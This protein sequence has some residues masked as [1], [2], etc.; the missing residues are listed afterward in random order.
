MN[1]SAP[2]LDWSVA[3]RPLPGQL[4]SGDSHL[5]APF[6]GGALMAAIDGL[7]HG[8]D[9]ETASRVSV[10]VMREAPQ[11]PVEDLLRN[12][13]VALGRLRGVVM[14]LA[15]FDV[16]SS[17]MT[18]LGVGNVEG[19]LVRAL[20]GS[21]V[22]RERLL[23]Q[24]GIVGQTL[25]TMRPAT[26]RLSCNDVIIFA[27]DGIDGGFLDSRLL[28]AVRDLAPV[29]LLARGILDRHAQDRDDALVLAARYLGGPA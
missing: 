17:R 7:G 22:A 11:L 23:V 16:Q 24:G 2:V 20:V 14:S 19:I 18:W 12:C 3:S 29:E 15:S 1:A 5:V 25:P 21:G 26:V 10:G 8:P 13:H 4:V 6:A 27:T 28:D 9:A